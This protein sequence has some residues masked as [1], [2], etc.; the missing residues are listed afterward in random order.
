M[1]HPRKHSRAYRLSLQVATMSGEI[2]VSENRW[3][4]A[5]RDFQN[6]IEL[7]RE[8]LEAIVKGVKVYDAKRVEIVWKFGDELALLEDC[9]ALQKPVQES[10]QAPMPQRK[11]SA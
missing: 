10:S 7:T 3:L 11:E 2:S 1:G 6:P 8:M 4:K 9:V 5:A